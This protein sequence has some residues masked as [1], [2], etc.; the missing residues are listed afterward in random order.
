MELF[1]IKYAIKNKVKLNMPLVTFS[2]LSLIFLQII[3][4]AFVSGMDA[5]LIYNS[6]PLNG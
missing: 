2:L 5:G 3:V 6:W 4:G 1:K